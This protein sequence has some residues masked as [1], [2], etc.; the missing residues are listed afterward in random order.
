MACLGACARCS[1]RRRENGTAS[2]SNGISVWGGSRQLDQG[3]GERELVRRDVQ[4]VQD[5]R[6]P[7]VLWGVCL[8]QSRC[9]RDHTYSNSTRRDNVNGRRHPHRSLTKRCQPAHDRRRPQRPPGEALSA[10]PRSNLRVGSYLFR[11]TDDSLSSASCTV[12]LKRRISSLL[13]NV[14]ALDGS[15]MCAE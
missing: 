4:A 7:E 15:P 14:C 10:P 2:C 13:R 1:T 9:G 6:S 3:G 11:D 8:C 5:D 12:P